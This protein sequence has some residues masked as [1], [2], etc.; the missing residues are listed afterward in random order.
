MKENSSKIVSQVHA[1]KLLIQALRLLDELNR[2]DVSAHVDLALHILR[3]TTRDHI[4]PP[5]DSLS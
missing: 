1:E 4:L 5:E 2:Y 3:G